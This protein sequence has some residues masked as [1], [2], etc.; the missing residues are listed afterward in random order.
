MLR[1]A[2]RQAGKAPSFQDASDDLRELAQVT[3]SPNHLGKLAERVGREWAAA[4][5]ADVQAFRQGQ[6]P[7]AYAQAP[8]YAAP[9]VPVGYREDYW[10]ERRW[11]EHEWRRHEWREQRWREHEW[12]ERERYQQG[13][14]GY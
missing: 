11:R 1:Q 13:R 12:H 9:A 10:R 7:A 4:R 3:I 6:L 8:V 5:D 14:W 2:V